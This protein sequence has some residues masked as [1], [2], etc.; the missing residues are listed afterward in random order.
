MSD[1]IT[2]QLAQRGV[3]VLPKSLRDSY[4]LKPGDSITIIDLGGALVLSPR[5]SKIDALANDIAQ[6][7]TERGETLE[8]M[9][10]TLREARERR[11]TE[12]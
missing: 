12:S 9:L 5:R 4:N 6:A 2:V 8:A 1:T 11:S 7:L 10:A 3:I